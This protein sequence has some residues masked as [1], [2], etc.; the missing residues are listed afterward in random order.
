LKTI[1]T[2]LACVGISAAALSQDKSTLGE[3]TVEKLAA[4]TAL[5][6]TGTST[7]E[8]LG[9]TL[10]EMFGI[11]F[12]QVDSQQLEIA[13]PPF[14]HYLNFDEETGIFRYWTGIPVTGDP[15]KAKKVAIVDYPEMKVVRAM[16]I[17]PYEEFTLSYEKMNEYAKS[18]GLNITGQSIEFYV[19]IQNMEPDNSKWRTII[20]FPLE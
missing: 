15:K 3:I 10:G 13:G 2:I 11:I 1:V 7:T 4:M 5:V 19:T 14:V 6:T 17:G 12:S 20:C 16:H 18:N 9:D 8:N